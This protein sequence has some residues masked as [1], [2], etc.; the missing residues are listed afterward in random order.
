MALARQL[1]WAGSLV[2][3]MEAVGILAC[4]G[5]KRRAFSTVICIFPLMAKDPAG[6]RA[7]RVPGQVEF[8]IKPQRWRTSAVAAGPQ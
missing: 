6:C 1:E 3:P 4:A 7:A 8:R 2:A 5:P